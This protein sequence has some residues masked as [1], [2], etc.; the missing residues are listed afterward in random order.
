MMALV[1]TDQNKLVDLHGVHRHRQGRIALAEPHL[2]S[3]LVLLRSL[4]FANL[5]MPYQDLRSK[6]TNIR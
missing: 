6:L 1:T 2:I 3:L 5:W 4:Y